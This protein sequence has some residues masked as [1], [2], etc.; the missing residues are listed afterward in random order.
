MTDS[1]GPRA[2]FAVLAPSTNTSVQPEFDAMRPPGVTNHHSRLVIPDTRVRDDRSFLAM[3]DNI[4]GALLP[5][6]VPQARQVRE[7]VSRGPEIHDAE[8]QSERRGRAQ[9]GGEPLGAVASRD[10]RDLVR[11]HRSHLL[12]AARLRQQTG[13]HDHIATWQ[14]ER[15]HVALVRHHQLEAPWRGPERLAGDRL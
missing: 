3:M 7:R 5:A 8:H 9:A 12:A 10:V 13:V 11:Q 6:L 15:V 4:R 2:K 1:L 14:S